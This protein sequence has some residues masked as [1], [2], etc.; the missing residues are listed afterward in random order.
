MKNHVE[1]RDIVFENVDSVLSL[2]PEEN[3][4]QFVE[5]VSKTIAMAFAGINEGCPGFLQVIYF[6]E[7]PAGIILIGRSPVGEKESEVLQKFEYVYRLM[8]F[9][10]DKQYQR[11]GIGKRSLTLALEKL[12]AYNKGEPLPVYLE[13]HK[14]NKIAIS[15]YEAVG[16]K[17]TNILLSD[18]NYIL[19]RFPD[20]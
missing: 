6:D 15:L 5:P 1:L 20:Y 14:E 8:G 2:A 17:N 4:Q 12:K 9:F 7:K 3:Q 18:D 13:C 11:K 19:I 16:F 10:I